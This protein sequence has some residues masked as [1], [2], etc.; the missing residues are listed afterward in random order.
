M[1]KGTLTSYVDKSPINLEVSWPFKLNIVLLLNVI[2]LLSVTLTN[3]FIYGTYYFNHAHL[4]KKWWSTRSN[5]WMRKNEIHMWKLKCF[6]ISNRAQIVQ[7]CSSPVFH[8]T[9]TC[10]DLVCFLVL[11][12]SHESVWWPSLQQI[13]VTLFMCNYSTRNLVRGLVIGFKMCLN[14]KHV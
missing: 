11:F 7:I 14:R 6:K 10:Y 8:E 2:H 5:I 12:W 3:Y 4:K 13:P 1:E 9:M